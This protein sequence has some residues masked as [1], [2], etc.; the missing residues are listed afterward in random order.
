MNH[1]GG[2]T[3]VELRR[4]LGPAAITVYAVGDILGAGIYALVGKVVA[5]A[6]SGA[7]ISFVVSAV[8]ALLTGL[9]YAELSSR[10]PVAA[11]AA[12]YCRRAYA[13]P[14]VAFLV[15]TLVLASGITSAAAVSHAFVGYLNS[16]IALPPLLASLG[17]LIV[18]TVIN[19]AGIEESA[20]VNLVLT[21]VEV[22]GL[23]LVMIIG[24]GYASGLP[25]GEWSTRLAPPADLA[26]VLAGAGIAFYAYIGFEDTV[27]VAEEVHEPQRT[28][29]RAILLAIS[30]TCA[31]YAA[32]AIAALLTVP[33]HTLATSGAPLLE[34][35]NTAGVH[36]PA[37][38]FSIVALFAICNT[39]LLNL[40]M[41]SRL[42]YGMAREGLLPAGLTRI[43]PVRRTPWVAVL[44]A[45]ALAALLAASGGVQILAQTT[46]LLLLS[47][48]TVLHAGL[49]LIKRREAPPPGVFTT[50]GWTPVL[51]VLLCLVMM[52]QYPPGAYARAVAVMALGAILYVVMTRSG[53][54]ASPPA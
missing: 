24:F 8:I 26:G 28:L 7:W 31:I 23:V 43:H 25:A 47:V 41:A 18:M 5:T 33:R 45:F 15:G 6:D 34:V 38:T 30:I 2:E 35:L 42:S 4:V 27:N 12:A 44:V 17:L 37:G 11:G 40:I 54:L 36:L 19:Y 50:P 20:R 49:A 46:S 51:G 22:A 16:F 52:L 39:G 9:T 32:V 3:K 48:F 21:L 29:P 10:Y 53:A 13:H 14:A 1:D